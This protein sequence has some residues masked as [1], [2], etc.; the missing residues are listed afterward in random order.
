MLFE[1]LARHGLPA[2]RRSALYRRG[3]SKREIV[4]AAHRFNHSSGLLAL[5]VLLDSANEHYRGQ[6]HNKAMVTPLITSVLSLV[7]SAHGVADQRRAAHRGRHIVF[8][9]AALT[10]VAGTAFHLY[11]I[12]KKPGGFCWQNLFYSAPLGAPGAILLSGL[13]GLLAERVRGATFWRMPTLFGM[14]AGR[15][16]GLVTAASLIGTTGEAALLHLRGAFHNPFMLAPVTIPPIGAGLLTAATLSASRCLRGVTRAWL[17]LTAAMGI[18]GAGFHIYG[19][20]RAMGGWRNWQ[21]NMVDGPP[22]PAPPSFTALALAG[23]AAL[24]LLKTR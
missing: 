15:F 4:A 21:Q 12:T 18:A 1:Q 14:N 6:F 8:A 11:N 7:A 10:G 19:V 2:P 23:L 13:M 24:Q 3:P 5:S 9:L 17:S 16:A 22:I 20:S